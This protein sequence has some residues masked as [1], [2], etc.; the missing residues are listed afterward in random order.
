MISILSCRYTLLTI[1]SAI[2]VAYYSILLF[3]EDHHPLS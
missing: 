2:A 3:R 1:I